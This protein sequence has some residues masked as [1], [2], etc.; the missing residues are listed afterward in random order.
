VGDRQG[1]DGDHR[2]RSRLDPSAAAH[3]L[4]DVE[5]RGL[6]AANELVDRLVHSIDGDGEPHDDGPR[7]G[8]A[9]AASSH[10]AAGPSAAGLTDNLVRLWAELV[11]LGLDTFGQVASPGGPSRADGGGRGATLDIVTGASTGMVRIEVVP[12]EPASDRGTTSH[13]QTEVWLHNGSHGDYA[14]VAL[15]CGDLRAS[16][17]AVLPA[18]SV[19][20]D[21]AAVDLPA[22]SSRG[23][24]IS[25]T[26]D[27]PPGTYRGVV[28]ATGVPDAWLPIEVVVP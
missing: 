17:G 19:R 21:P 14:D 10:D 5:R 28:L 25:V 15:H 26:T 20:F 2:S 11:R 18:T 1:N 27:G 23:V 24:A 4:A 13:A 12:P 8:S 6:R 9:S 7:D 22:R 16:D 3:V